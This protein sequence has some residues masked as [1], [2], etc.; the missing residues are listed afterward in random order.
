[1][2]GLGPRPAI[3]DGRNQAD[4]RG[5]QFVDFCRR[6]GAA[7]LYC[8]NFL[9][10]G[11]ERYRKDG[12]WGDAREAADWVSY[13][14]DPDH[15]ERAANGSAQPLTV[16]LWQLGN[17]TSYGNEVF[18]RDAA[19][20]ATVEFSKAMR[21]RDRTI[22]LLGWGDYGRGPAGREMW[23]HELL[24]QAGEH[25]DYVAFH[26]MGMSPRRENTLL[27]GNRYQKDPAAAWE[28][29]LELGDVVEKRVIEFEQALTAARA[30]QLLT[31]TEGHLSLVPHN[32]NPILLEWLSAAYHARTMNIYHRHG[33]KVRMTTGA[34]FA[35]NRWTVNAVMLQTPRGVSYLTPVGS[36]MRLFKRHN[37]KH[38]VAVKTGHP[39]L[40][41]AAS[42]TENR[43]F[44]HVLN[45]S[46]T[47]SVETTF[48]VTGRTVTG[49]RV[50][51]IAPDEART[52]VGLDQ[53]HVFA[54]KEHVAPGGRWR[55]PAASVSAVDLELGS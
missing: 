24:K 36:I 14:N 6:V 22:Q 45:K 47:R 20:R 39:D 13:C 16:K 3:V 12:R 21:E 31:I 38:G 26:M 43:V 2:R 8:V 46:F 15:K 44:L 25:I 33:A 32:A 18:S 42:R 49:A 41:I 19:I 34:D 30:R 55:F 10:D 7:P 27:R 52:A 37:G 5:A 48:H 23:A 9:G 50:F 35:G 53:P 40:D 4:V 29:L 51:E 1:E 11:V 17:E 54:P 28:E